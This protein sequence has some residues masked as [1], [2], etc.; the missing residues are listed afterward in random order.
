MITLYSFLQR[1]LRELPEKRAIFCGYSGNIDWV[2]DIRDEAFLRLQENLGVWP[3][4]F[5]EKLCNPEIKT[6]ADLIHY[7]IWFFHTHSGGEGNLH[8]PELVDTLRRFFPGHFAI[9][10][11]GAQAAN[12]LA[13]LGLSQVHLHLPVYTHFFEMV[14]HPAL[15][16]HHNTAFFAQCF[17]ETIIRS[18]SEIHCILDYHPGT[19]YRIGNQVFHT[20][21][22]D[23]IILSHDRCNTKV[24]VSNS[25]REELRRPHEEASFLV[26]G[27][28]SFR[29]MEELAHF[30]RENEGII[31]E[32]RKSHPGCSVCAEEAHYW[33][34]AAER[35]C[36]VAERI[37]PRIDSL[38][39]NYREFE[40]LRSSLYPQVGKPVEFLYALA[41]EYG[42]KRVGVHA[43]EECLVVSSY[44]EE[45]EM[46][47]DSLG[48]LLSGAKAH[49]GRFVGK[50]ELEAFLCTF[51][52]LALAKEIAPPEPLG[53]G[54]RAFHLP[55]L[56]GVPVASTLGLG[57]AFT[58][59]LLVYL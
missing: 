6:M 33:D 48:I 53:G 47:A 3:E 8:T 43:K 16:I 58:A 45:Q 40:A 54:Y 10:G 31:E 14:L 17:G 49:Y 46:L 11:T 38:G 20:P 12:F 28:N 1:S 9:G 21:G 35:I 44:P 50:E 34:R 30:V 24:H 25:F 4:A 7:A 41:R 29:D 51:R 52:D 39:M 55:T 13:H 59:G 18:L 56:K 32:F 27:F 36:L 42:L 57:D 5:A 15:I 37:Y 19:A 26:S 23:R 2:V 22:G